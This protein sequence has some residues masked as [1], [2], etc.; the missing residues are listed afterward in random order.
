MQR[1]VSHESAASRP[2]AGVGRA[3]SITPTEL[4]EQYAARVYRF[5]YS[6]DPMAVP[7]PAVHQEMQSIRGTAYPASLVGQDGQRAAMVSPESNT[8]W[9][10]PKDG[11][12][13][14]YITSLVT[15][16]GVYTLEINFGGTTAHIP[17][18]IP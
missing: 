5:A 14:G 8:G 9:A 3:A 15:R 4:C 11:P 17:I 6:Y 7:P 16:P 10:M 12:A 1:A 18:D 2:A 13:T